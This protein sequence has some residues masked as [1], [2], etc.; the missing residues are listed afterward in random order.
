MGVGWGHGN[1]NGDVDVEGDDEDDGDVDGA[2]NDAIAG[3]LLNTLEAYIHFIH[4]TNLDGS[5]DYYHP[6]LQM[7][8]Q[9]PQKSLTVGKSVTQTQMPLV[10]LLGYLIIL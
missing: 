10:Q 3:I 5:R 9:R 8:K 2:G 7:R 6:M 4:V 1:N